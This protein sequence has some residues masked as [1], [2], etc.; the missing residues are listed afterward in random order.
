VKRQRKV[1]DVTVKRRREIEA[2]AR[3][4][5]AAHTE[6]LCTYLIAWIWNNPKAKD[7]VG[8]V[9]ECARRMRRP[10]M[11][12]REAESII[13]EAKATRRHKT[14]DR[15]AKFLGVTFELRQRVGLTTIGSVD[16]TKRQRKERRRERNRQAKEQRRRERG[17]Q[18]RAEYEAS[19]LSR[20]KPWV[21]QGISRR[22]WERRRKHTEATIDASPGT[23]IFLSSGAAVASPAGPASQAERK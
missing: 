23:P 7:P 19:S 12:P 2:L 1:F 11:S 16:V 14:A 5:G 8:A 20:T 6:D 10:G 9:I 17:A 18:V 22:T 13:A 21:A 3:A 4:V 15:L